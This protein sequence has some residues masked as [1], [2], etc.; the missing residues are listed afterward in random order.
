L[1]NLK[2]SLIK[3][4]E[5][6]RLNNRTA[7][8]KNKADYNKKATERKFEVNDKVYLFC[9]IREPGRCPEFR[10]FWQRLF[11]TLQKSS[12]LNYKII[13]KKGK[14]YAFHI[15]RLKKSYVQIP[16]NLKKKHFVLVMRLKS[17]TETLDG[18]VVIQSR[19]FATGDE[20]EPQNVELQAMQEDTLQLEKN[21][22]NT[23][24]F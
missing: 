15:N 7:Q 23:R 10:W 16:W 8:Q 12:D 20:R 22:P 9:P 2:S 5:E 18:N 13:D 4:Y 1:G 19:P 6:V 24:K 11:I 3:V 21:S 14:E 17:D